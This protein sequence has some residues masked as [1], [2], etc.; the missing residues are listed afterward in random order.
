MLKA[1]FFSMPN[2]QMAE[3][4]IKFCQTAIHAMLHQRIPSFRK[5]HLLYQL[6]HSVTLELE[7]LHDYLVQMFPQYFDF[8]DVI[9]YRQRQEAIQELKLLVKQVEKEYSD[10]DVDEQLLNLALAP[11]HAAITDLKNITQ[12]SLH[13]CRDL[14]NQLLEIN[15]EHINNHFQGFFEIIAGQL[16]HIDLK[17]QPLNVKINIALLYL[18]Y[19][20]PA[21]I[22]FC[23]SS[24]W[25]KI[26]NMSTVDKQGV[27]RVY[28]KFM[29]QVT[30]KPTLSY[31]LHSP[32][33][34]EQ[35]K[36]WAEAELLFLQQEQAGTM[37]NEPAAHGI[38]I[39]KEKIDT[40][41]SS[42]ELAIV[43]D[44]FFEAK[45]IT[46]TNRSKVYRVIADTFNTTGSDHLTPGSIRS[47]VTNKKTSTVR[48]VIDLLLR[49]LEILRSW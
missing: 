21:Y 46:D 7:S 20:A 19:N 47:K 10:K 32:P 16:E 37:T 40:S 13:Y 3:V 12:R 22:T 15:Q 5:N 4:Y 49:C 43:V 48:R 44:M 34:N 27:M 29:Q 35:I 25:H 11:L 28:I 39:T 30:P 18:N 26:E 1:N 17:E 41:L 2:V 45:I 23:I 33:A 36:Q 31:I 24:L 14:G 6:Y 38:T 9:T 8:N 42:L